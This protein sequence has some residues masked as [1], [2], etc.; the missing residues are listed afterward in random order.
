MRA[1][2]PG[3]SAKPLIDIDV[4]MPSPE[5]VLAAI[6]T[7]EGAGY[8]NRGNRYERDVYAFM[9]R[10]TKPTRRIYLLPQ[11]NETHQKRIIFR[12][13][14][15]AHPLIAAE[16]SVLKQ[17]LSGKYAYDGDGYTRAKADF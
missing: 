10:S 15:I 7:M 6:N 12:D 11:G 3:L 13:Y 17:I 2:V 5:R 16:Y 8:E 14:L 4:T 9:M 1:R